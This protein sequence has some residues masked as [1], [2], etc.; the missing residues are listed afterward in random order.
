MTV[1]R[2]FDWSRWP[3]N[4]GLKDI[5]PED[6]ERGF[7]SFRGGFNDRTD[8]APQPLFTLILLKALLAHESPRVLDIGCGHGIGTKDEY[9]WLLSAMAGEYWGIEPD[10]E[11][12]IDDKVVPHLQRCLLEDA[13][14]PA[15]YFDV[16]FAMFV[17]EHLKDPEGF[18]RAVERC[19]KPGGQFIFLTSNGSAFFTL[20]AKW[21]K[22]LGL[23]EIVHTLLRRAQEK[24]VEHYPVFYRVNKPGQI[25]A[26]AA[27]AGLNQPE[28]AYFQFDGTNGY[29]PGPFQ[30]LYHLL[31]RTRRMRGNPACLDNMIVRITKKAR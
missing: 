1:P 30:P 25:N 14:L 6:R 9:Q 28:Y 11:V 20:V 7:D 29:F 13:E 16:A 4:V 22:R 15:D 8:T 21:L 24:E 19:L 12:P 27:S 2:V 10:P 5:T 17:V 31:M 3:T 26:A 23:V 18:F